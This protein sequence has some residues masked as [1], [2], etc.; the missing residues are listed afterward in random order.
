MPQNLDYELYFNIAFFAIIGL[1]F[2]FG[3]IRGLRKSLYALVV[4]VLF[5]GIF[6]LT[7]D[8]V[9]NQL[10]VLP[11][12]FLF[13]QLG[14]FLPELANVQTIGDAVFTML[15]TNLPA[16]LTDTLTNEQFLMF[17]TG[18]SM[19][20]VKLL[21]TLLYF[22]IGQVLFKFVMMIIRLM[23]FSKNQAMDDYKFAKKQVRKMKLKNRDLKRMKKEVRMEYKKMSGKEKRQL[24]KIERKK[25]K[26]KRNKKDMFDNRELLQHLNKPSRSPFLG[27]VAGAAKGAVSAFVTL[28]LLGGMLNMMDSIMSIIPE[29]N[30]ATVSR[31]TIERLY[32]SNTPVDTHIE[33]VQLASPFE[34]PAD[35]EPQLDMAREMLSAFNANIFVTTASQITYGNENYVEEVPLHLYLFD[36]V[37][38]FTFDEEQIMLRNELDV[39]ANT[40]S[41]L[42]DSTYFETNNLS[43]I[44]S[45][46]IIELFDTLSQSR[47]VTTLLPLGIEVGSEMYDTPMEV[48]LDELYAI[49]WE[50]ELQTL[51]SVVATGFTI[52][53]A[54]G[55]LN[56]EADLTQVTLDGT[57]V[58]GLFDSLGE[59][60]LATLGAYV[61]I[62]PLLEQAGGNITSIITVPSDI[63]WGDEFAAFGLVAEAVLNTDISMADLQSGD[64]TILLSALS[65]LDFTVLLN[66]EIVTNALINVLSGEAGIEG[67]DMIIIPA[68]INWE[69]MFDDSGALV[70]TGELRNIL[71]AINEIT[72]VAE[73]FD[74]QNLSLNVI[75]DFDDET[76]DTIFDSEVLVATISTFILD[77]DLGS[78]PLIIPDS[79]IDEFGYITSIELKAVANSA[80]VLVSDLA[81]DEGDTACEDTGFDIAKAFSISDTSIDTLTSSEILGATIGNLIIDQG[82]EILT[83]PSSAM[84]TISV[85]SVE[86]DVVN[87]AEIKKLFSAVG[88]LGFTDL[89]NMT[90]D[91][92]I[93][94]NLSMVN[95][96]LDLDTSKSNKLFASKIVHATLSSMLFE[97]TEGAESVL[98]VPYFAEDGVTAIRQMDPVDSIEYI[99]LSEI[100]HVL[101]ALIRINITDFAAVDTLDISEIISNSEILLESSVLQATISKQVFDLGTDVITV[102]YLDQDEDAVRVTVGDS[103]ALTDTEYILKSEILSI[104]DALTVLD[105]TDIATFDGNVDIASI[106]SEPGNIDTLL[107]SAT[108]HATISTQLLDLNTGGTIAVPYVE[109][110]D[111]TLVRLTVGTGTTETEYVSKDEIRAMIDV[112]VILGLTEDITSFDGNVDVASIMEDSAN[113]DA[114]LASATI[115][116]T[117]S[118]QLLDLETAGTLAIPYLEVDDTTPVRITVGGVG[119]ETEYIMATEIRA[120]LDALEVLGITEDINSFDGNVDIAS[121]TSDPLNIDTLLTSATIHATISKQLFELETGGTLAVPYVKDDDFTPVRSTV[122][123]VGFETEYLSKNEI[124]ALVDALTVLG[125]TDDI[126]SFD[127][128]VDI[129]SITADPANLTTLLTSS[130]IQATISKQL[131]DLETSGTLA[132][133]YRQDDD[134]TLVRETVGVVGFETEYL[135]KD[136]IT[137]L[138]DALTILGITEDIN[139]FDGNVDIASITSDPTNID[140]LLTSATIQATISKQ[141]IDLDVAGTLALPYVEDDDTTPVR[142]TVGDLGFETE[143]LSKNEIKALVDA[144][145][146]L[147]ITEDINSFDGNV[148]IAS[149]TAEPTNIDTLLASAT[150]QATISK[151]LIDLDVAGTL[152]LPYFKEDDSTPVR[153]TVGLV[154]YQTEYLS[155]DEIKAL[156]DALTVLGITDDINTFTGNVDIDTITTG[157]NFDVIIASSVIQATMSKQVIDLVSDPDM[158]A[159]FAVPYFAQ[160][161]LT[162]I[163]ITVGDELTFTDT[164]YINADELKAMIDGLKILGIDDVQNFTGTIDLTPFFEVTER[165]QLLL[166]SILHATISKQLVELGDSTLLIPVEDFDEQIIRL[167]VGTLGTETETEYVTKAEIGAMFE[168]L[169]ALGFTDI[170]DFTGTIDLDNV[171]GDSNQNIIL[172]SAA[173]HA[174]ISKQMKDLPASSLTIPT[175][176]ID[177]QDIQKTVL[178]TE[179]INKAEIKAMI[180]VLELLGIDDINSFDGSFDFTV[181]STEPNQD[182]LLSSAAIHA[183]ITGKMLELGDAVLRV[184]EF[185]QDGAGNEIRKTVSGFEYVVK[186]EIKALINAFTAMGYDDLDNFPAEFATSEFFDNRA[187]LLASKSIQLT[188]SD[189]MINGTSGELVIPDLYYGT[190]DEIRITDTYGTYIDLDEINAIFTSLEELGFS[191]FDASTLDF[192]PATIFAADFNVLFASASIQA[193]V[194]SNVIDVAADENTSSVGDAT[195]I[196]PQ[197]FREA[198]TVG[199]V[200]D[201]QIEKTELIN[202]MTSLDTL[203]LGDFGGSFDAS[204]ITT[205]TNGE[206]DI[207]LASGSVHSTIDNMLRANGALL[208]PTLAEGTPYAFT[209]TTKDEVK[210]FILATQ[211][212]LVGGDDFTN[213][214]FDLGAIAGLSA[215]DQGV[216]ADSMIVR[217]TLTPQLESLI[218]VDP[219]NLYVLQDSDYMTLPRD[220]LTK[221]S[222]LAIID[223]YY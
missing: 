21:Y 65:S 80:R 10:W 112:L 174:T 95:E 155:K 216:V 206:L 177:N 125:I 108:I 74:L 168:S 170:N 204:I 107:E 116:A 1:G 207:L 194:S 86:Q 102:P 214:S 82:G 5:Y 44:T 213:V 93:I 138:V 158:T 38:S 23:F 196:V 106:T 215:S 71:L 114:L 122:G 46:E 29:D 144:L 97:Q 182:I 67:L 179:F 34:V 101:A 209:M 39:I 99:S 109:E 181:L 173:M 100:E 32:L 185:T 131:F 9:V 63:V 178:T 193:T 79:V 165:D 72:N 25:K 40:A 43:D 189:K 203:G 24:A 142:M 136:E 127:G 134:S 218:A 180:N 147:G 76:I 41:I 161:D 118:K 145:T 55:I 36:S 159:E 176:D 3:Y 66:S 31:E 61:A 186:D 47:L 184:P 175:K 42:L 27:S 19:F 150:I 90:F 4:T 129:A 12:P 123:V 140:T 87:N 35:L 110:D 163:R 153:S 146:I 68:G 2:I 105:I 64:P 192:T 119:H 104:L 198:I 200:S 16:N 171:Y 187:V 6:F 83:V 212:V 201:V 164:E 151:Q 157:T 7:I 126:N 143:Y 8:Q 37:L 33:P 156:V 141:L 28:I 85:D 73:G 162:E 223:T 191:D 57:Q 211:K 53:N 91:A 120:M 50:S 17:V 81:C 88:V 77:M 139:S 154:G 11:I 15:E 78:T 124:K 199:T 62:E 197:F 111:S 121:I 219:F 13:S 148:D 210:L 54:A 115:Q 20:V 172:A 221:S 30:N 84:R 75:A 70:S 220:F 22:T 149:I 169:E 166:S 52:I 208:I 205:M 96:P 98:A 128:N 160:D 58:K 59:S 56:D 45:D 26:K 14:S 183:T 152:T 49:D 135:S 92:S 195:I 69:D 190:L 130:T 60:E 188:I 51:G 133:P 89:D 113:I 137:A 132:V 217:N 94:S 222:I 167:K 48:P 202:L 103:L 117:I 18:I